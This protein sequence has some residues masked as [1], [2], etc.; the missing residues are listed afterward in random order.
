MNKRL[1]LAVLC[2]AF[3]IRTSGQAQ[4]QKVV[5]TWNYYAQPKM[6]VLHLTNNSGKDITAYNISVRNK[7]ADGTQDDQGSSQTTSELLG[8]LIAAQ[9]AKGTPSEKFTERSNNIFAA[10]TTRDQ[11][12]PETKDISGVDAVVDVVIYADR[13][14]DV[15]NE[16]AL[17]RIWAGR[18]RELLATQ[19]VNQIIHNALADPTD[20]PVAVALTELSNVAIQMT[21]YSVESGGRAQGIYDIQQGQEILPSKRHSDLAEHAT[22]ARENN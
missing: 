9:M 11:P 1:L 17:K 4:F 3:A 15:E 16:D 8:G 21:K 14:K 20:H 13:T 7:Y 5:V 2:L 22:A 12:I 19:K 10:G 6:L 18:Q